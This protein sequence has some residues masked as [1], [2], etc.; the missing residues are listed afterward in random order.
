MAT[1]S[2]VSAVLCRAVW[3]ACACGVVKCM[4]ARAPFLEPNGDIRGT[5]PNILT[6]LLSP[7]CSLPRASL[8]FYRRDESLS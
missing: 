4:R 7:L 8:P 3:A 2:V 1:R 5:S 6:V